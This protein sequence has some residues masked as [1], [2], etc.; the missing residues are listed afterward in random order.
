M[1]RLIFFITLELFIYKIFPTEG[2]FQEFLTMVGFFA[3]I[4]FLYNKFVFKKSIKE[5]GLSVG[6]YKKGIFWSSVSLI[7][8]F[9]VFFIFFKY[10]DFLKKYT[11]PVEVYSNFTNFVYYEIFFL[12]SLSFIYEIF[13]RGFIVLNFEKYIGY[14]AILLQWFVF[15][16]LVFFNGAFNW[17]FVPYIIFFPFA[18]LIVYKSRSIF[19]SLMA[20]SL[21]LFVVDILIIKI[22]Y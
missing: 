8:A 7:G 4:P 18:G 20:Q 17:F 21:F 10:T 19:Y 13:F 5:L 16:V 6:E 11:L 22:K 15:L 14:L 12:L 1:I 9:V 3:V 2:Y